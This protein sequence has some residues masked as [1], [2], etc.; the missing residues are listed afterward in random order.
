[1]NDEKDYY[2]VLGVSR[3]ADAAAI[4]KH[5]GNWQKSIIRTAMWEMSRQKSVSKN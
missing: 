1:M 2:D 4:K 3:T 5:T